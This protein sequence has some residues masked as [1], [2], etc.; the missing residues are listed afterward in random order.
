MKE[1]HEETK[2]LLITGGAG[3]I[4]RATARHF[5]NQ[6]SAVILTDIRAQEDVKELLEKEFTDCKGSWTYIRGDATKPEEV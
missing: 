5:L 2:T 4:G 3:F 1:S 6:G